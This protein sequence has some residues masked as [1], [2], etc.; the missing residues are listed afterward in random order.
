MENLEHGAVKL[1]TLTE[2]INAGNP[3]PYEQIKRLMARMKKGEIL[4]GDLHANNI[5][6]KTYK[7]GV[8]RVYFIDY[9]RSIRIP[10][11]TV[12]NVNSY[13]INKGY[14]PHVGYA[15][16]YN[17]PNMGVPRGVNQQILNRNFVLLKAKRPVKPKKYPPVNASIKKLF[18]TVPRTRKT[19][20]KT[21]ANGGH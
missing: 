8:K 5:L 12:K 10:Y 17:S 6:I 15:G 20:T 4:H 18:K 13:L 7:S 2:F 19:K 1:Q 11:K 14:T 16:Y 9:G 21:K 3:Y